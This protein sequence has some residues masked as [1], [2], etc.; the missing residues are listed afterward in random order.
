MARP[1]RLEFPGALYHVTARGNARARIYTDE[2]DHRTFLDLLGSVCERFHWRIHAYCLMGNH[3][4]LVV[5]TPEPTL[6][7]GMRQMNGVYTQAFNRRH[8]KVGHLFQGRYTA[9]LADKDQYLLELARYVVLNPVRAAM[10]K[11]AGQWPWSSYRATIGKT[12]IPGWLTVDALLARF[13]ARRAEARRRYIRFIAEGKDQPTLWRQLRGQI[14]L[15]DEDFVRTLQQRLDRDD[16]MK[17]IPRAQRR[18]APRPIEHYARTTPDTRQAMAKA[19]QSGG[20]TLADIAHHFDV[21]YSTV[22]RAVGRRTVPHGKG[23]RS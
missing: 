6:A 15:G 5:E 11:S 10:V 9:I 4:H 16:H 17:E 20:Y 14:Y 19:Y 18:P 22:S 23:A 13:A 12:P 3:Y 21:H 8:R 1:L 2:D 7:R